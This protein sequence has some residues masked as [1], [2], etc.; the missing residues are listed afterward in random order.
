MAFNYEKNKQ[1]HSNDSFWTSYSDLFLGLST[2][3]LLLYVTSSLRTG[4][5]ALQNQVENQKLTMQVEELRNQLKM[6]ESVKSDYMQKSASQDEVQ[7]YQELIDKLTLLESEAKDE[8]TRLAQQSLENERKAKALNK[9]QQMV[10]NVLNANKVAK[11]RIIARN[12]L[13]QEQDI[14]IDRQERDIGD[15]KKDIDAKKNQIS[16]GER[17]IAAA[18]AALDERMKELRRSYKAN[19]I[20]KKIFE[21]RQ[22]QLKAESEEKIQRLADANQKYAGQLSQLSGELQSTQSALSEKES[23]AKKLQGQLARA[24]GEAE[25]LKGQ[26]ARAAGEADGLKGQIASLQAG[27]AAEKAR[28][29]AAFE[30]E[31]KKQ[32]LGAAERARREGE[33][34]AAAER[35]EKELQGRLAGLQGRLHD[36][37]GALARAK[38]EI[39]ARRE[40]AKDIQKAFKQAGVK[41]DIDMQTGEVVLD[42]GDAYFENDSANL[43]PEMRNVLEKAM[44]AYSRSLFGNPKLAGKISSVEVVGFASPTYKGRFVDP[45]STKADDRAALKYNMDLSY[46]RA[47]AIF[48]HLVEEKDPNFQHQRELLALMKV[49]GR[50]FLEV[51]KVQS[52]GVANAAEFCRQ[53]DCRKAQRV[54]VRFNMENK[55]K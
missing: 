34:R 5:D 54:I 35:K 39:D 22:Q 13:I 45:Y 6:Y 43:K 7:E 41:A 24:S 26:L 37:E 47:N 53:N 3:F 31:L 32:K 40:I 28:D 15:L 9:Y 55:G 14:E 42:F 19:K 51:M 48:T 17:K 44:P 10:R 49:S 1:A 27:H 16:E 36:T 18:E 52:R 25:G 50:S 8:K 46:R 4:T 30:G 2:I 29:R 33:F 11:S 23:E 20:S 38:E 12:D 21:Q